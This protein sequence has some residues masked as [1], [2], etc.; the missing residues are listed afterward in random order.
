[1][2]A[3]VGHRP[4]YFLGERAAVRAEVPDHDARLLLKPAEQA[5]QRVGLMELDV[6]IAVAVLDSHYQAPDRG[7]SGKVAV[8]LLVGTLRVLLV[9]GDELVVEIKV[10]AVS[11][12][13]LSGDGETFQKQRV[14]LPVHVECV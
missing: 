2:L 11:G 14:H 6:G 13:E 4:Q 3:M 1:M 8:R 7:D 9:C 12:F 5:L 10:D